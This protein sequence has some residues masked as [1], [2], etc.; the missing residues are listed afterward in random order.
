MAG[1][2]RRAAHRLNDGRSLRAISAAL[3]DEGYK[4]S[5]DKPFSAAAVKRML[6]QAGEQLKSHAVKRYTARGKRVLRGCGG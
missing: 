4:A 2:A 5:S 3:A 1:P 6:D